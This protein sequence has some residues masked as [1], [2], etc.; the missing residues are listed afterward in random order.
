MYWGMPMR[1]TGELYLN[2]GFCSK[3]I[4]FLA[5]QKN[6]DILTGCTDS[7]GHDSPD[8]PVY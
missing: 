8:V 2:I 4:G 5:K 3:A 1:W 7:E 6:P